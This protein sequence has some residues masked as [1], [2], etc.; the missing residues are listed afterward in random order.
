MSSVLADSCTRFL[1]CR[2]SYSATNHFVMIMGVGIRNKVGNQPITLVISAFKNT[3]V[4]MEN[5]LQ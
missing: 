3:C 4:F 1:L 5:F 2:D